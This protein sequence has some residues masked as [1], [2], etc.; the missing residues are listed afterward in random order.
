MLYIIQHINQK[1]NKVKKGFADRLMAIQMFY[2]EV[3]LDSSTTLASLLFALEDI[4]HGC[5]QLLPY[6]LESEKVE[7]QLN[8]RY[9]PF[10]SA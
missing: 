7:S 8:Q 4:Q 10:H 9:S 6:W 2:F 5:K 1:S 3:N